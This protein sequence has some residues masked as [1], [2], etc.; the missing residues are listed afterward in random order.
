MPTSMPFDLILAWVVF[1][2]LVNTHQRHAFNF[3]G[4]SQGYLLALHASLLIGSLVG[5]GL[6][7]YYFS[8]VAW[9]WPVVLFA[10]GSLVAGILFGLLDAMTGR[11]A[12]SIFAFIGWPASAFW[13]FLIIQGLQHE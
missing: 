6:M 9:Y 12:M 13:A 10:F 11:L 2:G 3:Q 8:Q 1:F 7:G 5:I 4:G